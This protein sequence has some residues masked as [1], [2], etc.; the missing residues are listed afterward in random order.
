MGKTSATTC[1]GYASGDLLIPCASPSLPVGRGGRCSR[2]DQLQRR[3]TLAKAD[4]FP[5][6]ND[7]VLPAERG[8][9][10]LA[11]PPRP[12]PVAR[13]IQP[14]T[15]PAPVMFEPLPVA[16][17]DPEP[18]PEPVKPWH[19]RWPHCLACG[20]TERRYEGA[21]L[22]QRCMTNSSWRKK[23]GKGFAVIWLPFSRLLPGTYNHTEA[24][25]W[26]T[27]RDLGEAATYLE[28]R[29]AAGG[30]PTGGKVIIRAT[31]DA[32]RLPERVIR[33]VAA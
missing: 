23:A 10:A 4:P 22:C 20:L 19:R 18:E 3:E 31:K 24:E 27:V 11:H 7:I 5:S 16:A 6:V 28:R 17:P 26:V 33:P 2:C 21:G 29:A 1:I 13:V 8:L 9:D 32:G 15:P 25:R 12:L 14:A 30:I